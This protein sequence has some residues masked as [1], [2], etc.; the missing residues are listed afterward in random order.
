MTPLAQDNRYVVLTPTQW[1]TCVRHGS[2]ARNPLPPPYRQTFDDVLF[3][4]SIILQDTL[5]L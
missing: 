2:T 3:Q 1:E 5:G 4:R